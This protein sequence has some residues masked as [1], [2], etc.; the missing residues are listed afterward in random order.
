MKRLRRFLGRLGRVLA[1]LAIMLAVMGAGLY[2]HLRGSLPSLSGNRTIAGLKDRAQ[3]VR[4]AN[5][6]PHIFANS[7]EDAALAL[8]YAHAQD[9]LW[10]MEF[11]RR[12]GAGRVT[13]MLPPL[14]PLKPLL[15]LDRTMRGLGVYRRAQDSVNALQPRTRRILE[16]YA[17]GVNNYIRERQDSFGPEFT[18]LQ[19][20]PEPWTPADTLVIA[21][22][23]ALTLDGNWRGEL[24]RAR[25]LKALGEDRARQLFPPLGD[26]RD[27]TLSVVNEALRA[28][29]LDRLYDVTD[30]DATRKREA[31][32]EWVV[33][34]AHTRS[35]KPL[36][37]NDPHLG[38]AAPG[39]WYLARLVGPDFDIRGATM[40]GTPAVLLGHNGRIAWGFTTTNL[41][42]QDLFVEKIDPTNPNNYVTPEGSR[43]FTVREETITVRFGDPVRLRVR[44]TRH[45]P[46]ISD[47]LDPKSIAAAMPSG[48][49]LALSAMAL[50]AGDTSAEGFLEIGLATNWEQFLAATRKVVSPMQNMVYADIEGNIGFVS[51]ARVPIRRRGDGSLPVP[52][53]T[54]EYDWAGFV[55]FE[56]LPRA[57]NPPSGVIVNANA[58][59]TPESY[60]HFITRDWVEPYRQR[61]AAAML[62]AA[63]RHSV[64]SMIAM[65]EDNVSPDAADTLPL[66]L[67][68]EPRNFR[69]AAAIEMLRAWNRRMLADRPEPLIYSAWLREL[70]RALYADELGEDLF[71]DVSGPSVAFLVKALR[72]NSP[73]CDD[74]RTRESETCADIIARALDT[75]L[76]QLV[77]RYGA[78]MERWRWGDAHPAIHRHVLLDALPLVRNAAS[79][80]FPSDGGPHTLNRAAY[81][82]RDPFGAVHG[83]TLRAIY[84]FEDLDNSRFAIP[85]G[86]SG[87]LL[88]PW[89]RNFVDGWRRFDYVRV[90]GFRFAVINQGVG[91]INLAPPAK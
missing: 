72:E 55:P 49:V 88:S 67:A 15:D 19:V 43:A 5:A 56:E 73:W 38:L 70:H 6:V 58:R 37:A 69:Q 60:R 41:D 77:A 59:V 51:P 3:I 33:A 8:G 61:R 40:P 26:A 84:D 87:N 89:Y 2:F 90:A 14:G 80:R 74:T 39:T 81:S 50:D 9:R 20:T 83:A 68:I 31:S 22:L 34:G 63:A 52:G 76:E 28:L 64:G 71:R 13:E 82:P 45:G 21:K 47:V 65:Q 11:G 7:Y 86:Q 42:S 53:W 54:G 25:V 32:N 78:G 17:A 18:L 1:T 75:A 36:L 79:V 4:D 46:V 27:A 91:T 48:H 29:P 62:A 23:M 12:V 24:L 66:M 35:G 85:L 44:E 57:F 30:H 16:A 10:Q